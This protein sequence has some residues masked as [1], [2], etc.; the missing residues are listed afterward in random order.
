MVGTKMTAW[1]ITR[2]I[3]AGV[4][5]IVFG[6]GLELVAWKYVNWRDERARRLE[7]E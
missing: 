3:A 5:F 4:G 2:D 7:G 6:L 1:Q